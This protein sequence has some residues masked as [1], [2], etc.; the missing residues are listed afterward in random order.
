MSNPNI[1]DHPVFAALSPEARQAIATAAAHGGETAVRDRACFILALQGV[2]PVTCSQALW[3]AACETAR[4]DLAVE[5]G[6]ARRAVT[7]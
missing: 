2:D 5:A 1:Y 3:S 6:R 7:A 4:S